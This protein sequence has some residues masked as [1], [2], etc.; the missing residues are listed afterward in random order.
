MT[1]E[2]LDDW[3]PANR[4]T[5]TSTTKS[6]C[7]RWPKCRAREE[8]LLVALQVPA[9]FR[10]RS[11]ARG[12]LLE[13]AKVKGDRMYRFCAYTHK[14]FFDHLTRWR[15]ASGSF[16]TFGDDRGSVGS[17]K[18]PTRRPCWAASSRVVEHSRPEYPPRRRRSRRR[19][20]SDWGVGIF[21]NI[22]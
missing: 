15:R 3:R 19:A 22:P 14:P 16:G 4:V 6:M 10:P 8:N 1:K 12:A 2:R 5:S 18:A 7:C 13:Q 9:G 11:K 17:W 21:S 20:E